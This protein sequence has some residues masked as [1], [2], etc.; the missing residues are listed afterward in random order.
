MYRRVSDTSFVPSKAIGQR[1]S[2]R[3]PHRPHPHLRMLLRTRKKQPL[4]LLKVY[5]SVPYFYNSPHHSSF[6][7]RALS[8]WSDHVFQPFLHRLPQPSIRR[9]HHLLRTHPTQALLLKTIPRSRAPTNP[10]RRNTSLLR[11]SDSELLSLRRRC[12]GIGHG[13]PCRQ[14]PT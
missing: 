11:G 7:G 8:T 6:Q 10:N 14:M 1:P 12:G 4:R 5:R 3:P 2:A 9:Q 13:S